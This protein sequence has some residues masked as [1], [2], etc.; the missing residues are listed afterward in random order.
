MKWN[1]NRNIIVYKS[2]II[3]SYSKITHTYIGTSVFTK[4]KCL[5]KIQKIQIYIYKWIKFR[6]TKLVGII[7]ESQLGDFGG[8][9]LP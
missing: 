2:V 7:I 5:F 8:L 1:L 3:K 6:E 9:S 4:I